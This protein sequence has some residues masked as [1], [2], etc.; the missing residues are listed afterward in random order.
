MGA[1]EAKIFGLL[2]KEFLIILAVANAIALPASYYFM[3]RWLDNFAFRTNLGW[4]TFVF[5]GALVVLIAL[6]TVS[7]RSFEASRANPV[8]SLRYE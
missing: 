7:Y 5:S 1:S 3:N 2:S 4:I 6:G 8:D